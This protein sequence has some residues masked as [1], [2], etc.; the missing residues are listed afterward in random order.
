MD[1]LLSK[2]LFVRKIS[3]GLKRKAAIVVVPPFAA[4]AVVFMLVPAGLWALW[5]IYAEAWNEVP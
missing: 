2:G 5:E 1:G 4:L 3:P